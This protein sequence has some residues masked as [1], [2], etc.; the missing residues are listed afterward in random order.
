LGGC[1]LGRLGILNFC[2]FW[3]LAMDKDL[4]REVMVIKVM[5]LI[6]MSIMTKGLLQLFVLLIIAVALS[7]LLLDYV[8]G[9]LD[10]KKAEKEKQESED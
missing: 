9:V 2:G 7:G 10:G 5:L 8:L 3:V 1:I 4:E 6:I